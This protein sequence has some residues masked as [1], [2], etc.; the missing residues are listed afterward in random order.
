MDIE[1]WT[2]TAG[3]EEDPVQRMQRLR[4]ELNQ[5]YIEEERLA[6]GNMNFDDSTQYDDFNSPWKNA[7]GG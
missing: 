1:N 5:L 3:E 4:D 7:F 6:K 2:F